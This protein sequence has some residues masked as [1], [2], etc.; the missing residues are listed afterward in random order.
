MNGNQLKVSSDKV[1]KPVAVRY[2]W[3]NAPFINLFNEVDLPL[4]PFKTDDW[5]DTT[6][7]NIH[8]DF[9]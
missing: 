4:S 1:K 3:S 9:P 7:G 6:E 2:G 5:K 8:L